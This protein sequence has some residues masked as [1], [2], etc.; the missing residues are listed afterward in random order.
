MRGIFLGED[1]QHELLGGKPY[2]C[3]HA[4]S[5]NLKVDA[6]RKEEVL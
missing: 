1:V 2:K 3:M 6:E 4:D 5:Y